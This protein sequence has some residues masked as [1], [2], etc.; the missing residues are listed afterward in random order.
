MKSLVLMMKYPLKYRKTGF[1][2]VLKIYGNLYL[3][4]IYHRVTTMIPKMVFR[5]LQEQ[6]I[7]STERLALF[8]GRLNPKL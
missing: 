2:R 4:E 3:A 7:L 5:I 8:V 6:A 1:F